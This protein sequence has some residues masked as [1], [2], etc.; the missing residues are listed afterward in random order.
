MSGFHESMIRRAAP[1]YYGL[2][3]AFLSVGAILLLIRL[4]HVLVLLFVSV[5]FASAVSR[6]AGRLEGLGIPRAIAALLIYAASLAVV[7]AI[8][9]YIV[10]TLFG[11]VTVLAEN[12]PEYAERYQDLERRYEEF[13][14]E[15]P[16]L[17]LGSFESQVN[18]ARARV[19]NSVG[20]RLINL[21]TR[22]FGVFLDVLTV[23]VVSM[24][25]I[26]GREKI[27]AFILSLVHPRYRDET[28]D[29]LT[30][31]WMRLGGYLRAKL[32]VMLIVAVLTYVSLILIGVPY[33]LLLSLLVGLG[34]IIPRVGAWIARVPLLAIAALE[35]L[36]EVGLVFVSSVIIQNLEGSLITPFIQGES[37]EMH[38]LTV[39]IAVLVGAGLL[40]PAGAFI[41]VPAAAMIQVFVE[42]VVIP[43]RRGQLA[44]AEVGTSPPSRAP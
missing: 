2:M 42:E 37:L 33:A 12:A 5:L 20:E 9:W 39:F 41:A 32:I 27:L 13:R 14:G 23:F 10:P 25:I 19:V 26:T 44:R 36:P 29:V 28:R 3:A 17:G 15:H 8:G 43:W 1:V 34:E 16:E 18:T 7:V 40:G 22:M 6:P 38:P 11:Q 31:M 30:K 21:P 24:L 4:T 35:G